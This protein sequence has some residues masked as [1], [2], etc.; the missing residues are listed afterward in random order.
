MPTAKLKPRKNNNSQERAPTKVAD[1][2]GA[3]W[4]WKCAFYLS[5]LSNRI[6]VVFRKRKFP[7]SS[8]AVVFRSRHETRKHVDT[9]ALAYENENGIY[10][11]PIDPAI[12]SLG[13]VLLIFNV[14]SFR[15]RRK[16]WREK[17]IAICSHVV[18]KF[19]KLIFHFVRLLFTSLKVCALHVFYKGC[20]QQRRNNGFWVINGRA[21][22]RLKCIHFNC[23]EH[24]VALATREFV[25]AS[26]ASAR[27]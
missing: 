16:R 21:I 26:G 18:S 3:R 12:W 5:W 25:Y 19:L 9:W 6:Y 7:F 8:A 10:C 1:E 24:I 22:R 15:A 20:M 27:A 13:A 23:V 14:R 4:R 2:R 11:D 17:T